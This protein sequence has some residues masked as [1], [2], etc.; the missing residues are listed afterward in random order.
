MGSGW[1][2]PTGIAGVPA[3][4]GRG[5]GWAQALLQSC[6]QDGGHLCG[7]RGPLA[8]AWGRVEVGTP[9]LILTDVTSAGVVLVLGGVS[10]VLLHPCGRC[11]LRVYPYQWV[12][13]PVCCPSLAPFVRRCDFS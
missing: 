3:G 6:L 7:Q 13:G 11:R 2:H 5:T 9:C 12:S 4:W 1:P 10:N 8:A